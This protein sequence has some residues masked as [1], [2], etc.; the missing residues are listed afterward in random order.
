MPFEIPSS[1]L[2]VLAVV[3]ECELICCILLQVLKNINNTYFSVTV[4]VEFVFLSC[5]IIVP[6]DNAT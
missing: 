3:G 4:A 5:G 1:G 6:D 2:K